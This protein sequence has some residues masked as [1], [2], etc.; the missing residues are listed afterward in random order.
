MPV[1]GLALALQSSC[2]GTYLTGMALRPPEGLSRSWGCRPVVS[3]PLAGVPAQRFGD[4]YFDRT[5]ARDSSVWAA[6]LG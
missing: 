5:S 1:Q 4:Q 6:S 3:E 2:P